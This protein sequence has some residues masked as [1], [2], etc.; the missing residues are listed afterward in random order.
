[1]WF[2]IIGVVCCCNVLSSNCVSCQAGDWTSGVLSGSVNG[3]GQKRVEPGCSLKYQNLEY[4]WAYSGCLDIIPLRVIATRL[5]FKF[6][7]VEYTTN[8]DPFSVGFPNPVYP[9]WQGTG[10]PMFRVSMCGKTGKCSEDV[11][12]QCNGCAKGLNCSCTSSG[13]GPLIFPCRQS[14]R[15]LILLQPGFLVQKE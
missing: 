4:M 2:S 5:L 10:L 1:M 12:C 9:P 8:I 3:Q 6:T 11:S 13:F 15:C 7:G 14:T